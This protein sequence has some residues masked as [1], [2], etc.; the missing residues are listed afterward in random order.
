MKILVKHPDLWADKGQWLIVL[1]V[2]LGLSLFVR[3]ISFLRNSVL[4]DQLLSQTSFLKQVG[5]LSIP[6][7]CVHLFCGLLIIIGLFTRW[8]VLLQIPVLLGGLIVTSLQRG[9]FAFDPE[10]GFGF[11]ILLLLLFFFIEG[12]GPLSCD[13]MMRKSKD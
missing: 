1:R 12:S 6:I 4:I 7:V 5:W 9:F 3:G 8:A 13:K 11:I 2:G 10:V